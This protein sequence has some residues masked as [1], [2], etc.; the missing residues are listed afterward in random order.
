LKHEDKREEIAKNGLEKML[1]Y[2]T[3]LKR[4][5]YIFD[6]INRFNKNAE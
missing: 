6:T 2:H 1:A 5:E 3:D 4:A